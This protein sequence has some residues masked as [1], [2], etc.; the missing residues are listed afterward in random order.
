MKR[1]I[2]Q[3]VLFACLVLC[4]SL[5][6][7]A[8]TF[9]HK[10]LKERIAAF[11]QKKKNAILPARQKV[12]SKVANAMIMQ[13][14]KSPA[15][16]KST[17]AT[18]EKRDVVFLDSVI[19]DTHREYYEYNDH[20]WLISARV[21]DYE[22]GRMQLDVEE[23]YAYE[24]EFDDK[25][26][27]VSCSHILYNEDG[28]KGIVENRVIITWMGNRERTEKYYYY[29]D[30]EEWTGL[31]LIEEIGYDKFGN[32]CLFKEY[33][34][35]YETEEMVLKKFI[36]MHF[37]D[38]AIKLEYDDEGSYEIVFDEELMG[39][40][41]IYSVDY[42]EDSGL[43]AYKIDSKEEGLTI[44]KTRY[45][46]ELYGNENIDLSK[47]DS[48]WEFAEEEVI[49][50]TPSRNRYASIY[51]YDRGYNPDDNMP[52]IGE[53]AYNTR[54]E[55]EKKLD[56]SY[57]FEWD[58]YERLVKKVHTDDEGDV[59]T[60]TCSY[61]NNKANVITLADFET[62]LFLHF[63][64]MED[65]EKC[66]MEGNFYG[67]VYKER[68][69]Y[70]YGF[71]ECVYDKYDANGN[72]LHYTSVEVC[73]S[74][75]E[76]G[77]DLNGDGIMSSER[78]IKNYE[79]W[80][81]RNE[82]GGIVSYIE[83]CDNRKASRTYIKYENV[84]ERNGNQYLLGYREYEGAKKEGPWK[85]V[86]EEITIFNDN[87]TTNPQVEPIGGWC[88]YYDRE[89][90]AWSGY[91]WEVKAGSY[92][93]YPIDPETGEFS[94]VSNAP[95]TRSNDGLEPGENEIFFVEDDWEYRGV[96]YAEYVFDPTTESEVL[97]V[98][99]GY[100]EIQWRGNANGTYYADSPVGNYDFPSGPFFWKTEKAMGEIDRIDVLY[101]EWDME[102]AGWVPLRGDTSF[103]VTSHYVNENGQI[104]NEC[105][106]YVFDNQRERMKETKSEI[107]SIY[108][109][110][111]QNRLSSIKYSDYTIHYIY[112]NDECNYLLESYWIDKASG[113]K[114]NVYKYY[115][116]D[117]KYTYPYS[118]VEK[119]ETGSPYAISGRV[120][121]ANGNIR[122]YNLNGQMVVSGNGMVV[123]PR[124]GLYIVEVDGKPSKALVR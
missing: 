40:Y 76:A 96:K 100:L 95:A 37:T 73:Y 88:R 81:T 39:K 99:H 75:E 31:E 38:C 72:V 11:E 51:F 82:N 55:S 21:Y 60:Y 24:Y 89:S 42:D 86:C 69:K 33:D 93:E 43:S 9:F 71:Y 74:D 28:S 35:D 5:D 87:P 22:D 52:S 91:K 103:T 101:F 26:R 2:T 25:D 30:G 15:H 29:D 80:I 114:Y 50:L 104:L 13:A 113:A 110:D 16:R 77:K 92:I 120:I 7:Q 36:E 124:S 70:K 49:T 48:Y 66:V 65:N 3:I 14:M 23:S 57:E 109:F 54:S 122:L 41:C 1:H 59:D 62:A 108:T 84:N 107:A 19:A 97:T 118:E 4:V 6:I 56:A 17:R 63:E 34:W 20:G 116:S 90:Q 121:T 53:Y 94:S 45:T 105:K 8:Q 83:Y 64:G 10:N 27:V 67:E 68:F 112:R 102:I 61:N 85:L 123:A 106:I 119:V 115:Y 98:I 111:A 44:T 78:E 79:T 46:I 47:L 117:G 12:K 58:E 32:P 18:E